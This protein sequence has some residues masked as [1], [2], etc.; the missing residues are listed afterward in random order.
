MT[1]AK[2]T[3]TLSE[4]AGRF[5]ELRSEAELDGVEFEIDWCCC[6]SNALEISRDGEV[7]VI[8]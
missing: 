2:R 4:W 8:C 7:Q 5:W 3:A 6:P 1:E